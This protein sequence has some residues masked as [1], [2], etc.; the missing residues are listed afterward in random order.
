MVK[1]EGFLIERWTCRLYC[2]I[3]LQGR[4]GGHHIF[5]KFSIKLRRQFW[6]NLGGDKVHS[7]GIG[8]VWTGDSFDSISETEIVL[9]KFET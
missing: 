8:S 5:S 2:R 7:P 1:S 9:Q 3:H 6:G 4:T